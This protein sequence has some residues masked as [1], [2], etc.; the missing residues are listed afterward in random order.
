[1]QTIIYVPNNIPFLSCNFYLL[2]AVLPSLSSRFVKRLENFRDYVRNETFRIVIYLRNFR[3]RA[4]VMRHF[5]SS[6]Y[7]KM[8]AIACVMRH[9]ASLNTL[10]MFAIANLMRHFVSSSC[11]KIFAVPSV[12]KWTSRNSMTGWLDD[13][14]TGNS[15]WMQGDIAVGFIDGP[16]RT[17]LVGHLRCTSTRNGERPLQ[18]LS[19]R[20]IT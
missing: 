1:M 14:V 6:S 18:T 8:F 17:F 15:T 11:V 4:N 16:G 9:F 2:S 20:H 19:K 5:V 13:W 10:E 7:V 12:V 3:G